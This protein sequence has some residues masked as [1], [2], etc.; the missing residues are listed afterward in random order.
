MVG[1]VF[2]SLPRQKGQVSTRSWAIRATRS[3]VLRGRMPRAVATST[4]SVGSTG[5]MRI[6][7]TNSEVSVM[8]PLGVGGVS[9]ICNESQPPG[10]RRVFDGAI[11]ARSGRPWRMPDRPARMSGY[12]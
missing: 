3:S 11:S 8:A 6:S 12:V 2:S 1:G 9:A 7:R 4:D 10:Q 5:L